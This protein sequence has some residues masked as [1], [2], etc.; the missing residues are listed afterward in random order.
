MGCI[1]SVTVVRRRCRYSVY[2]NR[3]F[4]FER[5]PVPRKSKPFAACSAPASAFRA[6]AQGADGVQNF[7]Q[8]LKQ[9]TRAISAADV[10]PLSQARAKLS[11]RADQVKAGAEKILTKNGASDVAIIDAQR[12]DYHHPLERERI[13]QGQLASDFE[14]LW[15]R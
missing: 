10:I 11:E 9:P 1:G 15:S 14:A 13:H 7:G 12:L 8:N 4:A 6:H 5:R 3:F 2:G